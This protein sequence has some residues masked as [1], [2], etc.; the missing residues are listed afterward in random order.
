MTEDIQTSEAP[1]ASAER[2]CFL[3]IGPHKTGTTSIQNALFVNA[4][5]L[6]KLGVYYPTVSGD[7]GGKQRRNHT[8]LSRMSNFKA[9]HL[10]DSPFWEELGRKIQKIDG[11][12]VISTEHFAEALRDESRYRRVTEFFRERGFRIVAV[13]YVRDQPGW[14][15]SW[16]TQDQRNFSSRQTFRQFLE[17]ALEVGLVDPWAYLKRFLDDPQAEVRVVSFEQAVRQGLARSFL[18]AIGV[19]A[20]FEI[21]EPKASNPN[22]GVKGMFAAQEIMRRVNGRVRS[23]PNY[24]DLYES[25]KGLMR[26]RDWEQTAYVGL[27]PDDEALIRE[28]YRESNDRFAR[29]WFGKDWATICPAR[30]L[31]LK[32]FDFDAASEDDKRDVLEV[33]ERMV[34]LI[35]SSPSAARDFL[36]GDHKKA[37]GRPKKAGKKGLGKQGRGKQGLGKQ[38]AGKQRLAKQGPGKQGLGKKGGGKKAGAKPAVDV[39]SA[40][41]G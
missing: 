20:S 14:L 37:G 11:S 27:S 23:L 40:A 17:H 36:K 39:P 3:H 41:E 1:A 34:D 28:R 5:R 21:P 29:E 2:I 4:D 26:G 13:A 38:G 18:D 33:V 12:I 10:T 35:G 6:A 31:E 30:S 24:S 19:P 16:Y 32:T 9:Q 7:R 8:P 22:I 25:F 15:N